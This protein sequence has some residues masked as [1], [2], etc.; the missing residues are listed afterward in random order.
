MNDELRAR[1]ARIDPMPP[2]VPTEA[3][4]AQSSQELLE[5]IISTQVTEGVLDPARK[6]LWMSVA[7]AMVL[8]V[9]VA[10]AFA[11][12]RDG[13]PLVLGASEPDITQICMQF[14]VEQLATAEVAFEGTAIS[15]DGSS[16]ELQVDR[17]FKG[18]DTGRVVLQAPTGMELLIDG[19]VF[20]VGTSYLISATDGTVDYCGYSGEAN[21][22]LRSAFEAA[23]GG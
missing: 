16:V 14:T 7:A 11:L 15:V 4:T 8:V 18:G 3:V 12:G 23:F 6:G 17:W 22:Q 10:A 19:I 20:E 13:E 9:G 1:L 2:G 5:E 21:D